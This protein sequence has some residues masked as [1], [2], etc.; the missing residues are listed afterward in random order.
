ME[1]T[2][3]LL[4]DSEDS[5]DGQ[6]FYACASCKKSVHKCTVCVLSYVGPAWP[7]I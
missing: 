1:I 5:E 4:T 6:L 3:T 7:W 2:Q